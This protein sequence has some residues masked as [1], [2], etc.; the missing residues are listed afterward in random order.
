MIGSDT[1]HAL[2]AHFCRRPGNEGHSKY[3]SHH[4]SQPPPHPLRTCGILPSPAPPP[5]ATMGSPVCAETNSSMGARG[6]QAVRGGRSSSYTRP[7]KGRAAISSHSWDS[8]VFGL[9][10]FT[11]RALEAEVE[12]KVERKRPWVSSWLLLFPFLVPFTRVCACNFKLFSKK[13]FMK[14]T[15]SNENTLSFCQKLD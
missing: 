1:A 8:T 15:P 13:L 14:F 6:P 2:W 12:R 3:I 5:T 10:S 11:C 7:C 9:L 4:P